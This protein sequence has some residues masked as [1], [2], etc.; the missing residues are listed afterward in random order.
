MTLNEIVNS[1]LRRMRF[2][3]VGS[4]QDSS[5]SL[6]LREFVNE[7][8]REVEDAWEWVQLRQTIRVVTSQ[9]V[10]R[11][12]LTGAGDRFRLLS[13]T[14]GREDVYNL[15]SEGFLQKA[16]SMR[17]MSERLNQDDVTESEPSHFDING[18]SGGDPQVDLWPIPD[19]PYT[20]N[21][22]MVIPQGDLVNDTETP[23]VPSQ[24]VMLGTWAKAMQDRGEDGGNSP[25]NVFIRYENALRD[26]IMFDWG[27]AAPWEN[28]WF[29][30]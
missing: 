20:I 10:F 18:Q 27:N 28:D 25:Q 14:L 21:F 4:V 2:S 7:T 13:D 24:S 11:Y 23:T 29:V 22:N 16:K 12:T 1:V 26:A 9:G 5:Y 30:V 3:T 6:L 15:T 17:W 8:K 19:K